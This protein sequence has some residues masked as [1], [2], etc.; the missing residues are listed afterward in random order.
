MGITFSNRIVALAVAAGISV[1]AQ[2]LPARTAFASQSRGSLTGNTAGRGLRLAH[3][4]AVASA[5]GKIFFTLGGTGYVCSGALVRSEHVDVVL[6]AAHC[7]S[8]G[9]G[10]WATSWTFV[11]GYQ[12]GAQPYGQYTARRF[13]VSPGWTGPGGGSE[14]YDIAFVQVTPATLDGTAGGRPEAARPPAGL[15]VTFASSQDAAALPRT[16]VFGYPALLPF[17][18]LYDNFCAGLSRVVREGPR[19]GSAATACSMTAGDSGGP[20]LARVSP[21]GGGAIVAVTTFKLS[22]NAGTLYGTVL[23]PAARALYRAATRAWRIIPT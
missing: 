4:G 10:R 1:S 19:R 15:P 18:G 6:T 9:R 7:V 3:G 5:V 17:S 2:A 13:F 11:P 8:D 22:G 14:R 23:G 12:G 16:Y 21:R 20:W